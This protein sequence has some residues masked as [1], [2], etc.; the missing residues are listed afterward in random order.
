VEFVIR[1][2]TAQ[3]GTVT[4]TRAARVT[5]SQNWPASNAAQTAEKG[6]FCALLKDLVSDVPTPRRRTAV[7]SCRFRT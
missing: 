3:D 4:E 7:R 6:Q 2:E 1:R 5:Y